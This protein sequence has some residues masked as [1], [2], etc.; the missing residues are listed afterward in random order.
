MENCP[1]TA[2]DSG[3][4]DGACTFTRDLGRDHHRI[5]VHQVAKQ[6]VIVHGNN[7]FQ[8]RG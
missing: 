4:L 5:H 1:E 3:M 7:S 8:L 6:V 2:E